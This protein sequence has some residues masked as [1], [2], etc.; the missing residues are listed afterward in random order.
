MD[1]QYKALAGTFG[2]VFF[3]ACLAQIIATGTG[4]LDLT[5]DGWKAVL[6]AGIGAVVVAAYNWLSPNDTRY[7]V[8]YEGTAE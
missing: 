6:G 5:A 2:K 3:A 8:G 4:V 1:T 7:G